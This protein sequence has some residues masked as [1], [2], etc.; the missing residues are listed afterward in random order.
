MALRVLCRLQYLTAF[1]DGM[2]QQ[3]YDATHLVKALKGRALNIKSW[4][5]VQIG[6]RW[7]AIKE[8]NKDFALEWFAE[9]AAP[10]VDTAA[11]GKK[12]LIPIPSSKTTPS[13]SDDFRTAQIARAVAAKCRTPTV[14]APVLRWKKPIPSASEEGGSRDARILYPLLSLM[15]QVPDGTCIFIDDVATLGGHLVASTWKLADARRVVE[16]ALC[17]GQTTHEQLPDPFSVPE[18][19]I[20]V[21]RR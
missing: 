17:G 5:S 18:R 7:V 8:A 2:R 13:S 12:V 11:A 3:D 16:L 1:V 6:G 20:D 14:V 19:L 21:T 15:P 10:F 4:A 9:W